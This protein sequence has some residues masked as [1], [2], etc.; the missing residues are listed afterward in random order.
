MNASYWDIEPQYDILS[1]TS[2]KIASL[3]FKCQFYILPT[4]VGKR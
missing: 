4:K 2:E 3:V 1:G